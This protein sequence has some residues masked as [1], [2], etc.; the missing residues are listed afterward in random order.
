MHKNTAGNSP[1][2]EITQVAI[3]GSTEKYIVVSVCSSHCLNA[4][5]HYRYDSLRALLQPLK[6]V[7][8]LIFAPCGSSSKS[9]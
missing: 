3:S 6:L 5:P 9:S 1:Q 7:L 2:L 4:S 8:G